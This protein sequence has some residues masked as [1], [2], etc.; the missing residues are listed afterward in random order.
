MDT[1]IWEEIRGKLGIARAGKPMLIGMAVVLVLVAA[2]TV[3]VLSGAATASDFEVSHGASASASAEASDVAA[4]RTLFVHVSGSVAKPGLY[5][6]EQGS[7]VADAVNAAGGF[8]DDAAED[9]CNLARILEDGEHIIVA[10]RGEDA[11]GAD[12]AGADAGGQAQATGTATGLVNI[13][14]ASADQLE[15]LPGIGAATA[16][17]IVADRAANGPFKTVD[18]LMRVSGIGEKKLASLTGLICV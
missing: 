3:H 18:D 14:M 13:N 12:A 1:G 17:K 8:A 2:A 9:S 10:R 5:E 4:P 15:S 6:L 7:R 11:A 16:Q